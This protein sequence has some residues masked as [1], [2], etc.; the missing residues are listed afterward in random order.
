[1]LFRS[2]LL[3]AA[4]RVWALKVL[5]HLKLQKVFGENLY[6]GEPILRKPNPQVFQQIADNF[7]VK[8]NQ[9][10][11]IGDQEDTD[12]IP[13][14]KIGMKT[15]RVGRGKTKADYQT[16]DVISAIDLLRKEKYL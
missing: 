11:S 3:T 2:A 4:P 1:V 10:F 13:A 15:I 12:I 5:S 9:V 7:G 6:T 14:K 8:P 16:K